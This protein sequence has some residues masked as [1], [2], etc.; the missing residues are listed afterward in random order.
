[1]KQALKN[2][3]QKLQLAML[4]KQK[5]MLNFPGPATVLRNYNSLTPFF[6]AQTVW[7]YSH[8]HAAQRVLIVGDAGGKDYWY[9]AWHSIICDVID[10]AEQALIP[11]LSIF[12]IS[13]KTAPFE[14][15]SFD[16]IIMC[17]VLEHLYDDIQAL[18]NIHSMLKDNGRFVLSGP[19]WH[20]A[21]EYH[22][23]LHSPRIIKR[24]LRHHGFR[25]DKIVSRGFIIN[26]YRI[27]HPLVLLTY[28]ILFRLTGRVYALPVNRRIY[29]FIQRLQSNKYVPYIDRMVFGERGE[30]NGYILLAFRDKYSKYDPIEMNRSYFANIGV[31]N[32]GIPGPGL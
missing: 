6:R 16:V 10:I 23:R 4:E 22:V 27:I 29:K 18:R 12:D 13:S 5:T 20:D 2:Y 26:F 7:D 1:M 15:G 14:P 31:P 24:M 3:W 25:V 19:Y 8:C 32:D 17:D 28:Y 9:F 21:P 11:K 30:A